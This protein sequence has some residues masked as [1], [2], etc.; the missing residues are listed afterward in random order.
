KSTRFPY[1]TL[2]RSCLATK[3]KFVAHFPVNFWCVYVLCRTSF[4]RAHKD[5]G[6]E[7]WPFSTR[8]H[9]TTIRERLFVNRVARWRPPCLRRAVRKT[10]KIHRNV[11]KKSKNKHCFMHI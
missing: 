10:K 11:L 9:A 6:R 8:D 3:K 1:T 4:F 7:R 5:L 2:F